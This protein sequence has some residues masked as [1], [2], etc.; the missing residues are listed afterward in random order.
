MIFT[1]TSVE[2][3]FRVDLEPISDHRGFFAR[4]ACRHEFAN[5]GAD[6]EMVQAN[7]AF[8][9]ERGTLRGLHFQ[10]PPYE[11]LKF[12]RCIG[13]AAYVVA[14]D[15]RPASPTYLKWVGVELT[16]ENRS[17]LLVPKGCVQGY[18]TLADKTEMLYQMSTYYVPAAARGLRYDDPALG[19]RWPLEPRNLSAKDLA[20]P[21]YTIESHAVC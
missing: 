2:G 14:A 15:I 12:V 18:Q 16:A 4:A 8:T 21:P 7:L 6:V 9:A 3:V 20:W 19:V 5:H 10:A 13:G 17:G 1:A 11:E